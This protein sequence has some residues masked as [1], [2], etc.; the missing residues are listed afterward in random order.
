MCVWSRYIFGWSFGELVVLINVID[1]AWKAC[2]KWFRVLSQN[3]LVSAEVQRRQKSVNFLLLSLYFLSRPS[4]GKPYTQKTMNIYYDLACR[5]NSIIPL[6]VLTI[7][8]S[9]HRYL[10]IN[11]L[12]FLFHFTVSVRFI[13]IIIIEYIRFHR[14]KGIY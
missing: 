9:T 5:Y 11:M 12:P 3:N 6:N 10:Q 8:F 4:N 2:E 1:Y 7:Q 14:D 13:H